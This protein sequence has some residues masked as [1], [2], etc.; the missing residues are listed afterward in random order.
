MTPVEI[1]LLKDTSVPLCHMPCNYKKK[2]DRCK[3][4]VVGDIVRGW[5]R[6]LN[7]VDRPVESELILRYDFISKTFKFVVEIYEDWIEYAYTF[8]EIHTVQDLEYWL[9]PLVET[10]KLIAEDGFPFRLSHKIQLLDILNQMIDSLERNESVVPGICTEQ[11]YI[12]L[13]G[14]IRKEMNKL[15]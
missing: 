9:I 5:N 3:S 6:V 8:L 4:S 15:F 14:D 7:T 2:L 12:Q 11:Q 13:M 10:N 1:D